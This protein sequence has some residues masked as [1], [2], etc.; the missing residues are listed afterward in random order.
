MNI[1]SELNQF[2]TLVQ[3]LLDREYGVIDDFMMP[4][5][6][7]QLRQHMLQYLERDELKPAGIGQRDN[8]QQNDA[9]RNDRIRWLDDHTKLGGERDYLEKIERLMRFLNETCFTGLRSVECHYAVYGIGSFYKKHLDQFQSDS[10]RRYSIILYLNDHWTPADGGQLV[11]YKSDEKIEIFPNGNRFVFFES[12]KL[13][14]EVLPA[15]RERWSITGW[16]KNR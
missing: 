2:E 7:V 5:D 4:M 12:D 6:F 3:Q 13:E 16:M 11:L 15:N 8:F 10:G 9:I 14:H 1:T